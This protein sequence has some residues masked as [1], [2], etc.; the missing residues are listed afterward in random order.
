[1]KFTISKKSLLSMLNM[2]SEAMIDSSEQSQEIVIVAGKD[3][4]YMMCSNKNFKVTV[5]TVCNVI[6]VGTML[7]D[8]KTFIKIIR[9]I[10]DDKITVEEDADNYANISSKN[11]N[12][13]IL[14]MDITKYPT[15]NNENEMFCSNF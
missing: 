12:I 9:K 2:V 8:A 11:T 15:V 4:L 10:N 13:N 5:Q 7:V 1:M 6:E 3:K 14:T